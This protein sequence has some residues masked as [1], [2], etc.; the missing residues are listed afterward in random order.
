LIQPVQYCTGHC[1]LA[2]LLLSVL[3]WL[4]RLSAHYRSEGSLAGKMEEDFLGWCRAISVR[5]AMN[6]KGC[7]Y[8]DRGA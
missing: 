6:F 5:W 2:S 4:V 7:P 1:L 3:A 8:L